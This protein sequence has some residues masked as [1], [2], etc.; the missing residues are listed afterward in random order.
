MLLGVR[1]EFYERV[2]HDTDPT[3]Y[4]GAALGEDAF[5]AAAA[6]R[7]GEK[8]ALASITG[9]GPGVSLAGLLGPWFG[10]PFLRVAATE[11]YIVGRTAEG[12]RPGWWATSWTTPSVHLV[13]HCQ[14][15]HGAD[16][17]ALAAALE[18]RG[19]TV[20]PQLSEPTG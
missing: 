10:G 11:H 7:A 19:W 8:L 6:P 18:D 9:G 20:D 15:V 13:V 4:V 3:G 12:G 2:E 1:I 16:A 14:A 5:V 17:Q